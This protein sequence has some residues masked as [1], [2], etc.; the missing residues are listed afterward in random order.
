M[1]FTQVT[2]TGSFETPD[3]EPALGTVTAELSEPIKNAGTWVG[4]AKV[5]RSLVKGEI[6]DLHL[7]ANDDPGTTPEGSFYTF[8]VALDGTANRV[9]TGSLP[10]G[11]GPIDIRSFE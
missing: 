11:S 6:A 2:V 8:T 5:V 7:V 9:Y 4:D 10:S 3:G 1:S